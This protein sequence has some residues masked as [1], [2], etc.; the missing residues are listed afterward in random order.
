MRVRFN[1]GTFDGFAIENCSL[2]RNPAKFGSAGICVAGGQ[3]TGKTSMLEALSG[4]SLPRY[5]LLP[6]VI[7]LCVASSA[8]DGAFKGHSPANCKPNAFE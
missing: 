2:D 7:N 8:H 5:L 6:P 3:S 1:R 4:I